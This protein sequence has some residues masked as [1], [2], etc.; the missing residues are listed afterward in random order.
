MLKGLVLKGLVLRG[1]ALVAFS[2]IVSV[3][4]VSFDE[5]DT[6]STVPAVC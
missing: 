6:V 4:Y 5:V 1:R 2:L 3:R